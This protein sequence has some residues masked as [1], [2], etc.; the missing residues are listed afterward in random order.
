MAFLGREG[1]HVDQ[2]YLRYGLFEFL[3]RHFDQQSFVPEVV[4]DLDEGVIDSFG[5]ND[6]VLVVLVD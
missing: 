4:I 2:V 3:L 1:T 6:G 5:L